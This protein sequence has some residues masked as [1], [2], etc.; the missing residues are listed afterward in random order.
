M[1]NYGLEIILPLSAITK[2]VSHLGGKAKVHLQPTRIKDT[3]LD[4]QIQGSEGSMTQ[5]INIQVLSDSS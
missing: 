3:H 1:L 5:V 2:T 4:L